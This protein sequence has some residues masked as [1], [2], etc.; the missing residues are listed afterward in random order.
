MFEQASDIVKVSG[1]IHN[2]YDGQRSG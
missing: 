1:D 2:S